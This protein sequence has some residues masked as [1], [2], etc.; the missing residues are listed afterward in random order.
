[1]IINIALEAAE[2]QLGER[3]ETLSRDYVILQN[4]KCKGV[5]GKPA[6]MPIR[7]IQGKI[8]NKGE[9]PSNDPERDLEGKETKL[10]KEI[11]KQKEQFEQDRHKEQPKEDDMKPEELEDKKQLVLDLEEGLQR[12]KYST[13]LTYPVEYSEFIDSPYTNRQKVPAAFNLELQ[14]P[15]V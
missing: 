3:K 14:I 1:M 11:N 8:Y 12:P 10:Q 13:I 9:G 15:R 5:D 4:V 2:K 7:Y 6:L